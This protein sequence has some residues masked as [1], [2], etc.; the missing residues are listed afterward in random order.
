MAAKIFGE[1]STVDD[2][3][4]GL[5][6]CG[7]TFLITGASAGL[8]LEAARGLAAHGAG[9]IL[10]ARASDKFQSVAAAL[11]RQF[12]ASAIDAV[13]IDLADLVSVREAG[14]IIASRHKRI[15]A[16]I[17]NAGVMACP[18]QYTAQGYEWQFGVNH[19]GHFLL[20][21]W[22]QPLLMAASPARVVVLSSGGHKY[23]GLDFDDLNFKRREYNKWL[24]YGQ[25]KT[26]NAL[27]AVALSQHWGPRVLANAVHPGAIITELGRHLQ[28][29]DIDF[30]MQQS[31]R[32]GKLTY[33][34]PAAG[35][36]TE[37]W[38]ATT[39]TLQGRGGLY[40]EDCGIA[41]VASDASEK[42]YLPYA[43][44]PVAA[45][46]LWQISL[47]LVAD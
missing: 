8:G 9:L 28:K 46:R 30:L 38:A 33:K 1:T 31:P 19:V 37:V 34:Q 42:G 11:R 35:A 39:A 29:E 3:L 27:F 4:S 6:L 24:S 41:D 40:L 45:E 44:D 17:N 23:G 26:A 18:L 2:V 12:P 15:D 5:D 43:L 10:A 32:A 21:Q 36:A 13:D 20:T 47:D 14:R 7:K 22:L 25:S 16:Q